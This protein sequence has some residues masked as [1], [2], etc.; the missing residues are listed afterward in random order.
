MSLKLCKLKHVQTKIYY[1]HKLCVCVCVC[2]CV[3]QQVFQKKESTGMTVVKSEKRTPKVLKPANSPPPPH[4]IT[5]TN[6]HTTEIVI[7]FNVCIQWTAETSRPCQEKLTQEAILN[8]ALHH[9][10]CTLG[11]KLNAHYI[12]HSY[13]NPR[14]PQNTPTKCLI[15]RVI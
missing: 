11:W 12:I 3:T 2:V 4:Y 1:T 5:F 15:C 9:S 10:L 7:P 8:R 13:R 6:I 14:K